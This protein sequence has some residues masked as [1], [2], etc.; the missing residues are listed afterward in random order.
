MN[1]SNFI[2]NSGHKIKLAKTLKVSLTTVYNWQNYDTFPPLNAQVKLI[3]LSKG[4]LNFN[5]IAKE[6]CKAKN[7]KLN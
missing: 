4:K 2:K 1:Y 3:R 6:Y 5:S 7:I